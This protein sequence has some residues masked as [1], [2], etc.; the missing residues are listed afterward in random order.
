ML[1]Q[2]KKYLSDF[3]KLLTLNSKDPELIESRWNER[4]K[5]IAMN[6]HEWPTILKNI[7]NLMKRIG[8]SLPDPKNISH[9]QISNDPVTV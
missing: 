9:I 7:N 5:Y 1:G 6:N 3:I 2:S 4:L 8:D